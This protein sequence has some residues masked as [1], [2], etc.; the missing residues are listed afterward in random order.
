MKKAVLF[1]L[2]AVL[3]GAPAMAQ[4]TGTT[5][6]G[7]ST[8]TAP[9]GGGVTGIPSPVR[10]PSLPSTPSTSGST[11]SSV[12]NQRPVFITGKVMADDGSPLP[13]NVVIQK[14]CGGS[15]RSVA[16]TDGRGQFSFQWGQTQGFL[17]DASESAGGR[18]SGGFGSA[19]S[20]GGLNPLAGD[21]FATQFTNCEIRAQLAGFRSDYVNLASRNPMDNPDVGLIV[22]HRLGNVE[23]ASVSATSLAAPKDA[24][25]SYDK[26]LQLLLKNKSEDAAKEFEKAVLAYPKYADAWVGLGQIRMRQ[27]AF[28]PARAAMLRA[29]ESDAKL[30]TPYIDL[31]LMAVSQQKWEEAGQYL[32]RG[33]RLD[34]IDFP[35]A[36][37]A[38]AVANYNLRK[39]DVAEKSAL[40]ALK[41]DVRHTNPRIQYLRGMIMLEHRDYTGSAE[42]LRDYLKYAPAAPDAARVKEQLAQLDKV[43]AD[44]KEASKQ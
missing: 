18:S 44:T 29:I 23:G 6:P 40:E 2:F 37:Y 32:D 43:T 1:S 42:Q 17:P 34:P 35:Q 38:D 39:F 26:G 8:G 3:T 36:W 5:A 31:G 15:A 10:S 27:N 25:K 7:G 20:A 21:P 11:P 16:Y 19:Q 4:S 33:L 13:M 22:L 14:V 24:K 41:L 12:A 30:V 9:S 28:E